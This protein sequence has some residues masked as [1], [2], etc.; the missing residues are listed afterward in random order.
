[1]TAEPKL[2]LTSDPAG[3]ILSSAAS[4]KNEATV[5]WEY[6]ANS[7]EYTAQGIAPKIQ[8]NVYPRRKLIEIHDN[9]AGMDDALLTHFF[10]MHSENLERKKGKPGRGKFGTGKSAAFG[11]ANLL[12]IITRKDGVLNIVELTRG[13][14]IEAR[15]QDK[16]PVKRTVKNQPTTDANGTTIEIGEIVVP[17]LR[18]PAI[19]EY[20]E[21]HL[22]HWRNAS[23]LV[24]VNDHL[25]EFRQPEIVK[26]VDFVP[27]D[28]QTAVL[29]N[30]KLQVHICRTPLDNK[31][32]GISVTAGHGNLVGLEDAGVCSKEY[33]NYLF[34]EVDVPRIETFE[35]SIEPYDD[36]RSLLLNPLHPVVRSLVGFIGG[37]LE[38]V[39]KGLLEQAKAARKD[40]MAR[41]LSQAANKIADALNED[42]RKQKERLSEIRSA[43]SRSGATTSLF[44]SGGDGSDDEDVWIAGVD[45][46]GNVEKSAQSKDTNGKKGRLAPDIP[47]SGEKDP[48]GAD[49]VSPAGGSGKRRR[50]KG[51]F[52]VEYENLG[53]D[54][55]RS[56][57]DSDSLRILINLDHTVVR[58]A[59]EQCGVEDLAF[60]RLSYEIAFSEYAMGLGVEMIKQDP[61]MP[62][63]D[64][65]YEVRATLNRISESAANLYR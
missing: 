42:F 43:S 20:I 40:E 64:L 25:C 63:D 1:V 27:N 50:P 45:E 11:I 7:L 9:G 48:E 28:A 16:V 49:S 29:G 60:Q 57:Y 37:S 5:V 31:N 17:K 32:R 15:G 18:V 39:R 10:R 36:S 8:V 14:I 13:D 21:R 61:D 54:E 46:L 22:Q 59:L 26:T 44:G 3:D 62:A 55:G 19:I 38:S 52:Q 23:P 65:L 33:G 35:T 12:R 2:A 53:E 6:V 24:A 41:R 4:F 30:V 58:N 56:F 51:G 47:R 34:G